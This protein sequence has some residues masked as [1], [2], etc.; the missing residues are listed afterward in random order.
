MKKII[1]TIIVSIAVL[2]LGVSIWYFK[3]HNNKNNLN[4]SEIIAFY[5]HRAQELKSLSPLCRKVQLVADGLVAA[6]MS[7]KENNHTMATVGRC[8]SFS[9]YT[10]EYSTINQMI[11]IKGEYNRV[12]EAIHN[13]CG[14]AAFDG[15]DKTSEFFIQAE[16]KELIPFVK[17][18]YQECI[19]NQESKL[20]IVNK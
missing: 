20:G 19:K 4:D 1:I 18:H 13:E 5:E 9:F 12:F 10:R 3:F 6:E 7:M 16:N 2:I 8:V 17:K 15:G 14:K 11:E